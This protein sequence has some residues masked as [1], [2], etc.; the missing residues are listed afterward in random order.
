[1]IQLPK[2]K[3]QPT[4]VST[5][6]PAGCLGLPLLGI[7]RHA[8]NWVLPR[9]PELVR[10]FNLQ[11][12]R[13]PPRVG[14]QLNV[15]KVGHHKKKHPP[16]PVLGCEWTWH[17]NPHLHQ[18]HPHGRKPFSVCR[19]LFENC[20]PRMEPDVSGG[21]S[22]DRAPFKGTACQVRFHHKLVAGYVR[23]CWCI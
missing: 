2:G 8:E 10:Q 19:T 7:P 12:H 20:P 6:D 16:R 3:C 4:M 15:A 9:S 14:C 1:M 18:I 11:S 13:E 21:G 22:L 17:P 23:T 5:M